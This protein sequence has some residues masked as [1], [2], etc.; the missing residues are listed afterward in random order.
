MLKR[1]AYYE[2]RAALA[3]LEQQLTLRLRDRE[4]LSMDRVTDYGDA[5]QATVE[6]EA[7]IETLTR[8]AHLH[9][10]VV[11]ALGRLDEGSYGA[12]EECDD[13][14]AAVRLRAVPWARLCRSCE[15]ACEQREAC[16]RSKV[17]RRMWQHVAQ[18]ND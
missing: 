15:E 11:A 12:C 17:R 14:I 8:I 3:E 9:A 13:P 4:R 10:L 2:T 5:V 7:A 1:D 6:S 16:A 18:S